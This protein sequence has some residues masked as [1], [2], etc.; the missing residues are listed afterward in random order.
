MPGHP[1]GRDHCQRAST[2]GIYRGSYT[3]SSGEIGLT[4][5]M[6]GNSACFHFYRLPGKFNADEGMFF[7]D[8]SAGGELYRF[9]GS[10][11]IQQ[12]SSYRMVD[13]E[14]GLN[15]ASLTCTT[16]IEH[17][18][19]YEFVD[20]M[21]TMN[22]GIFSGNVYYA[23]HDSFEGVFSLLRESNILGHEYGENTATQV[24]FREHTYQLLASFNTWQDTKSY[25]TSIGGYPATISD[26]AENDFL[27]SYI[28]SQGSQSAFFG[29]THTA[30]GW[31]WDSGE[32]VTYLNW[33]QGQIGR[34]HV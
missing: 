9:V 1:P 23:N 25:C 7:M 28:M 3:I 27:Q 24:K 5:T 20:L 17:P 10:D 18:I 14:G 16:W 29:L 32:P 12:P 21:G 2:D 6:E 34:A 11:W 30:A 31:A 15:G 33:A 26:K 13:L 8:V 22:D 19:T 4:L